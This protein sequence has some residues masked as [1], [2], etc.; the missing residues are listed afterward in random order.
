MVEDLFPAGVVGSMFAAYRRLLESL[1]SGEGWAGA[2]GAAV[3]APPR[4]T[5]VVGFAPAPLFADFLRQAELAPARP[6]VI[7]GSGET[8]FSD[9]ARISGIAAGR[10]RTLGAGPEKVVAVDLP[11]SWQQAAAALAVVRAGAAYL[12]LDPTLPPAR[13]AELIADT[14][15]LEPDWPTLLDGQGEA[16][17]LPPVDPASLAYVIFTSGSTGKPKG[18]MVEHAAALNTLHD[19]HRRWQVGPNDRV[20]GLSAL[21]F[22]LSV[23][24]LFGLPGVGGALVLPEEAQR[25]DPAAWAELIARHRVTVWNTVPAL[26]AM[27]AE[28]GLPEDHPLRL[29]LLSGDWIPLELV[30]KLRTLAPKAEL[31]SLGGATE[32]AIWSIFHPIDHLDPSWSSVPYGQPLANQTMHV[33]NARLEPCPD[34]VVGEIE[35]GGI[36]LARGYFG[37]PERT[38]ERFRTDPRTGERRYRTG[39]LGRFRPGGLIEFLGREDFQVK[40]QGHRIELGEIEAKLIQHPAVRQAVAAALPAPGQPHQKTLHAFVVAED[41]A[42]E[43]DLWADAVAATTSAVTASA[44]PIEPALFDAAVDRLARFTA[45]AAADAL[46]RLGGFDLPAGADG[47]PAVDA[48]IERC[49]I[50]PG[51]RRWLGRTLDLIRRYGRDA[52][53][54][55]PLRDFAAFD[56]FGFGPAELDLLGRL[57]RELPDILSGRKH[58][59]DIYLDAGT[60]DVYAKLF[61]GPYQVLGQAIRALADGQTLSIL[62]VGAGLGTTL[63]GLQ[64]HLPLDRITYHF[65]D[66]SQHFIHMARRRLGSQPWLELARL[67]LMAPVEPAPRLHDVVIASSVLH[68]VP[69]VMAA[70]QSIRRRLRPG[71]LLVM[72]E[73][74]RFQPWYDMSMGLQSG[75]DSFTDRYRVRHPLLGR[76]AWREIL[77]EAG[78]GRVGI[79]AAPGSLGDLIGLDVILVSPSAGTD[80]QAAAAFGDLPT[81]LRRFLAERLPD[82]MVPRFVHRI[83]RLPLTANGKVDRTA[84]VAAEARDQAP[85]SPA[86]ERPATPEEQRIAELVGE[87]LHAPAPMPDQ[88]FFDLGADSLKLVMIQRR[89]REA[90]G[91]S[92]DMSA[93]FADPTVRGIAAALAQ[94]AAPAPSQPL[95]MFGEAPDAPILFTVPGV[96]AMP[97]YLRMLAQA[98]GTSV[99]LAALQ[100]PGFF[101][102]VP[103][104]RIETQAAF[105]VAAMRARQPRG[106]YRLLGHSYGGTVA[107]EAARQLRFQG[108]EVAFLGLLDTVVTESSL[109]DFQNDQVAQGSIV[110]ALYAIYGDRLPEPLEFIRTLPPAEQL[111]RTMQA[112]AGGGLVGLDV[113]VD[114]VLAVFKANFRA[115]VAYH[116]G[117]YDGPLTL[118]R[119]EGGFPEEYYAYESGKALDDPA[120]GWSDHVTGPIDLEPLPGDHLSM[121][122]ADHLPILAERLKRRL[123]PTRS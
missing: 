73:E 36:G 14:Q 18:V 29:F 60:M 68:A 21:N 19:L 1:A 78:F 54:D 9:L 55:D 70:L 26:A 116:P 91:R 109:D 85:A 84:L 110:R 103:L 97:Y 90:M 46:Q 35:I 15:A 28:H 53:K 65:T 111:D 48:L 79:P 50:S 74:T 22:D 6:A 23:Y 12:P 122:D 24:D 75:F 67:D 71:G 100:L 123:A 87:V 72:I 5:P 105:L 61:Q 117:S 86:D 104:D 16:P 94:P 69:D 82:Y 93:L 59:G 39:D 114:G 121:L 47:L 76:D 108:E 81:E 92:L 58:A 51:Y 120:L 66:V 57:T 45:G 38:A 27:L 13:R 64:P 32:A 30:P 4:P 37:D 119:T 89:L 11:K 83:A 8:S 63:A 115:M 31:V 7:D 43:A 56:R 77:A 41:G 40:V 88:S 112:L 2:V 49:G 113:A 52:A 44:A 107:F 33:V 20:L 95:V 25:R 106:P 99:N 10:L 34:W 101:G 102:D 62:E 118:F 96:V 17:P 98:L 42:A 80:G 3:E